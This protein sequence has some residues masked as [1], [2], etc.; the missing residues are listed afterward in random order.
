MTTSDKTILCLCHD[1]ITL[2]VRRLLLE[3]FGF[4]VLATDSAGEIPELIRR[5]CPDMLLLDDAYPK[6]D[7]QLAARQAK[8][9]C[10]SLL[11]VVLVAGYGFS[12]SRDGPVDRFL[13]LDG[14]RD[15]WLAQIRS[16]LRERAEHDNIAE[17]PA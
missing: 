7:Y 10:P 6:V 13:N 2:Q 8:N 14:P 15:E 5:R 1:E 3:Y 12:P 9:I 4:R 11:A 17:N 16:L